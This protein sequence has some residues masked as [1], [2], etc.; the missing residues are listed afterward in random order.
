[1]SCAVGEGCTFVLN[2]DG[3]LFSWGNND[4]SELGLLGAWPALRDIHT[5]TIPTRIRDAGTA[6]R[7]VTAQQHRVACVMRDGSVLL[8]GQ[9]HRFPFPPVYDLAGRNRP[10]VHVQQ[11]DLEGERATHVACNQFG[12]HVV[13]DTGSVFAGMFVDTPVGP[14]GHVDNTNEAMR[15]VSGSV[16]LFFRQIFP[17][18]RLTSEYF[19][20]QPIKM[21]AAGGSHILACGVFRGLWSWGANGHGCL[22]HGLAPQHYTSTPMP[23]STFDSHRVT[24]VA[25]GPLHSMSISAGTSGLTGVRCDDAGVY[26]WGSN[27][28]G[29]LGVGYE[30]EHSYMGQH[31]H[32]MHLRP[33]RITP[34]AFDNDTI[35]MIACAA[36]ITTV[37]SATGKMW[38]FGNTSRMAFQSW[39]RQHAL[40]SR[41]INIETGRARAGAA[42]QG[43]GGESDVESSPRRILSGESED[44]D[45]QENKTVCR[46]T[47][48][49]TKYLYK[50]F[51]QRVLQRHFLGAKIVHVAAGDTHVAATTEDGHLYMFYSGII[52]VLYRPYCTALD[53]MQ[54]QPVLTSQK[55][56]FGG[57]PLAVRLTDLSAMSRRDVASYASGRFRSSSEYR[58]YVA[59]TQIR[60]QRK[61]EKQEAAQSAAVA[62]ATT[63]STAADY[64]H[65]PS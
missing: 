15:Y 36:Y 40:H 24:W 13:T 11:D 65:G 29:E 38:L 57:N 58:A 52:P 39:P 1:M 14:D 20:R 30:E 55:Q 50:V 34:A 27:S 26:G 63:A 10:L 42:V 21:V 16:D 64:G 59:N 9:G 8:W 23:V 12:W 22:G 43:H 45:D 60:Q 46:Y 31:V 25:A 35:T 4:Y 37:I 19:G 44:S 7:M 47:P 6:V 61:W 2:K 56:Y 41:G 3:E 51:P 54:S 62:A 5:T 18:V 28:A 48:M 17:T 32:F 49:E 33:I 53:V